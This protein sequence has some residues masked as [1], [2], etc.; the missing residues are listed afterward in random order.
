MPEN[1]EEVALELDK[2]SG[3]IDKLNGELKS[4][5]EKG[6]GFIQKVGIVRFSPFAEVG[7]DQSFSIALLDDNDNGVVI[8]S[9]YSRDANRVYAKP[10]KDS[11]STYVLSNE[12]KEAINRA[13]NGEVQVE[14]P[15]KPK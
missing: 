9:L 11:Q 6:K 12:E 10:I 14:N 4:F 5:K 15:N 8:T 3:R 13:Q 2:L 1:M 7:G